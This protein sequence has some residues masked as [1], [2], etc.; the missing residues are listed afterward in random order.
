MIKITKEDVDLA[1]VLWGL[2]EIHPDF[3]VFVMGPTPNHEWALWHKEDRDA[4]LLKEAG[5]D[6]LFESVQLWEA[7]EGTYYLTDNN[8]PKKLKKQR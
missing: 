7:P 3:E 6:K 2:G 5:E 8:K 1:N 4:V